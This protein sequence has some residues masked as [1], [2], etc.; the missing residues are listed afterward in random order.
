M[1]LDKEAPQYHTGFGL[2]LTFGGSGLIVAL[3]L[4]L[5][6]K[7][8][9]ANKARLTEEDIQ[10]QYTEAELLRMGDKSPLFKYIL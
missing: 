4:E 5:S 9:N 10:E 2:S 1:Y 8:G 7:W 6:Y 3:L